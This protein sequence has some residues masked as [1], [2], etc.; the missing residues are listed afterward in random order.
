[1]RLFLV[2]SIIFINRLSGNSSSSCRMNSL[3][4]RGVIDWQH[5]HVS[6]CCHVFDPRARTL[7]HAWNNPLYWDNIGVILGIYRDNGKEHGNPK[8]INGD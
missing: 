1:M 2:I 6:S 7:N 5:W 4:M 8:P 3:V